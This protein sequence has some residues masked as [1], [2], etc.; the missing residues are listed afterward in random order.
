MRHT[1]QVLRAALFL[2]LLTLTVPASAQTAPVGDPLGPA[3]GVQ[4][5]LTSFQPPAAEGS[6]LALA[7]REALD[8]AATQNLFAAQVTD[9]PNRFLDWRGSSAGAGGTVFT[10][11]RAATYPQG[12]RALLVLNREWCRAGAC[13]QRTVFGW[14]DARGLKPVPEADVIQVIRDADFLT[15]AAPACLRGVPLGVQ[16]VPARQGATLSILPVVPDAARRACEA[17]GVNLTSTLRALRMTWVA[18]AGKFRW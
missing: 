6:L 16:Y 10:T 8:W 3:R 12:S 9:A 14:L 17:A 1:G 13:Q 2:P 5:F 4:L 11:L 7:R 18:G 15:G